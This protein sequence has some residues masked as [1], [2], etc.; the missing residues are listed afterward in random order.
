MVEKQ[1]RALKFLY[2]MNLKTLLDRIYDVN[3]GTINYKIYAFDKLLFNFFKLFNKYGIK[4]FHFTQNPLAHARYAIRVDQKKD[5]KYMSHACIGLLWHMMW[6]D[7]WRRKSIVTDVIKR[8]ARYLSSFQ[9]SKGYL[10]CRY[11][12]TDNSEG[13]KDFRSIAEA[14]NAFLWFSQ[15]ACNFKVLREGEIN[16]KIDS[17][18]KWIL[19]NKMHLIPQEKGRL[20]Y[21]LAQVYSSNEDRNLI[22]HMENIGKSLVAELGCSWSYGLFPDDIDSAGGMLTTY[23][24]TNKKVFKTISKKLV[25]NLIRN[26][27]SDGKWRWSFHKENGLYN[28]W[29]DITY[30]VHQIGM[31]PYVLSLFLSAQSDVKVSLYVRKA[32]EKGI[33]WTVKHKA[34]TNCFIIRSFS[35]L[36]GNIYELEQRS[37]EM[38]LNILGLSVYRLLNLIKNEGMEPSALLFP[39]KH[40]K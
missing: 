12:F 25:Y 9:T 16:D 6:D 27:S 19:R 26:Q 10:R 21:A 37:Y 4:F 17:A 22:R 36:S 31:A 14:T 8:C 13:G 11:I 23:L 29:Q 1:D 5:L 38:G 2:E 35:G 40:I 20:C 39:Y 30:T 18:L 32:L 7:I 15:L 33:L 24:L 3:E 34:F 28:P